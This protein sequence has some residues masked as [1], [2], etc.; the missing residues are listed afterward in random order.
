MY[1]A[2]MNKASQQYTGRSGTYIHTLICTIHTVCFD[3]VLY[4]M[5]LC[6]MC[7]SMYVRVWCPVCDIHMCMCVCALV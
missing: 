6:C 4:S 1:V 5:L 2:I 3:V 7:M